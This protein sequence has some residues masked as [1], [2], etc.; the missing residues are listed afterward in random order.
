[1]W[2]IKHRPKMLDSFVGKATV[3]EAR[4]WDG[5]P[6]IIHGGT[7]TGKTLMAHLLAAERGYDVVEV[8]D[9]NI[10]SA[11][12]MANTGSLFGNP[13]M[14]LIENADSL[15]DIKSVGAILDASKSPIIL[16][17]SDYSSKRLAT[18]KK[19]TGQLQLRRPLPASISKYL[20]GIAEEEGVAVDKPVLDEIA[21][22]CGGD[23]RAALNDLQT[24]AVG[25]DCVR[26][27]DA[28]ELKPERDRQSDIYKA[29]S[30]IFGG[31][32]FKKVVDSTWDI[33]LELRDVLWWVEENA[34]RLYQDRAAIDETFR[35]LSKAD[36]YLGRILRRQYW[37]FLRY[38]NALITAGV[39]SSRP[40]KVNFTQY[41]FPG[42]FAA[43]GRSKGARNLESSISSKMG[44]KVHASTRLIRREYIPL[45]RLLLARKRV[46]SEDLKAE[47]NLDDEEVEYLAGG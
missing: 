5:K 20:Q 3:E 27:A 25:R 36:V 9:E 17:T 38:A 8:T 11:E 47:Y 40:A 22:G 28:V 32:E 12:N 35:N 10:S 24:L 34:P 26:A 23:L 31:R 21:K 37:G 7:G 1:M 44:P 43:M 13:R 16:T 45:Y 15:K 39:N 19:K 46:T 6:I 18:V 14:L 29:L 33:D 2:H 30:V 42:Y 4:K 41:M